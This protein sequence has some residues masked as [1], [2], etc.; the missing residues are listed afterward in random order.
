M[1][2]ILE[3]KT[4]GNPFE[5]NVWEKDINKIIRSAAKLGISTKEYIKLM[6]EELD[7]KCSPEH[8]HRQAFDQFLK[9]KGINN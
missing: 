1:N 3:L 8:E 9:R 5:L 7:R 6:M 4:G 2:P